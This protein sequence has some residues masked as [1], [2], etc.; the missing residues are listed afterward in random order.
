MRISDWSSDVC[1]SDLLAMTE[2]SVAEQG[3]ILWQPKPES[4][5]RDIPIDGAR[6]LSTQLFVGSHYGTGKFAL[7]DPA[8]LLNASSGNA[9]LKTIEEPRPD[10]H[11]QIGRAHV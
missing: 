11:L 4:K 5:R 7:I 2:D 1:S 10:T 9:L 8:D 6:S 3:L